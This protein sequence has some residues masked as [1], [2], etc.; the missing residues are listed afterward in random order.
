VAKPLDEVLDLGGYV[1][2]TPN[3]FDDEGFN[4][5]SRD[6]VDGPGLFGSAV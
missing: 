1:E 6:P 2:V 3:R 5:A 4:L